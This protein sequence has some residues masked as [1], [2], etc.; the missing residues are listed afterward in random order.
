[1]WKAA[2]TSGGERRELRL[3]ERRR[4]PAQRPRHGSRGAC[5]RLAG[6][7]LARGRPRPNTGSRRARKGRVVQRGAPAPDSGKG[8]SRT[9]S[10]GRN[11]SGCLQPSQL[12]QDLS[13]RVSSRAEARCLKGVRRP[14]DTSSRGPIRSTPCREGGRECG[15]IARAVARRNHACS[16]SGRDPRGHRRSCGP[17]PAADC[18][19]S[20]P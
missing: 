16:C 11:H 7:D 10:A 5:A 14:T 6:R 1:M 4:H 19:D 15:Q 12:A 18:A 20:P 2:S 13:S 9:P 3:R 17:Q 8:E